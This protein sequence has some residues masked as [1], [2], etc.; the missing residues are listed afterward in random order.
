MASFASNIH[1]VQQVLDIAALYGR[2]VACTGR[3]MLTIT[4]IATELGYLNPPHPL[5]DIETI[6]DYADDEICVLMTGSQGEPMA[7]LSKVARG[8]NRFVELRENDSVIFSSTPIPG[9][10]SAV[11]KVIN[12][13]CL[14]GAHVY[15]PPHHKVHVSG[16]G[17]NE[18]LKLMLNLTRPKYAIPYHGEA[19]HALA[20]ADLCAE[21][22]FERS[23]IP[24]LRL[25]EVLAISSEYCEVIGEVPAG[26]VLVDGLTIGDVG[27]AVLRDRRHL[28]ADGVLIATVILDKQNGEILSGPFLTQRGFLYQSKAEEFMER[29]T[30]QVRKHLEK[31]PHHPNDHQGIARSIRE[32]LA[33]LSWSA[34]Q[35]KP[36]IVPV[37]LEV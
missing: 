8:Q 26:S 25:G 14:N 32:S 2:K 22:G 36:L 5:I 37:V 11:Y 35:R 17:N 21:A 34:M 18:D 15:R 7:A 16:H 24:L 29:A 10:E 27:N 31:S 9:N 6:D 23:E 4:K 12:D 19:R 33:D 20:Y 3:S 1:R 13:L 30:E 28:A